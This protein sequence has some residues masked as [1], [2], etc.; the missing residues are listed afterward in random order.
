M[1]FLIFVIAIIAGDT[2]PNMQE[3]LGPSTANV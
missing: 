1:L 3:N 2:K